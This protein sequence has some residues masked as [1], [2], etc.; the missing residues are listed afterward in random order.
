MIARIKFGARWLWAQGDYPRLAT[1]LEP[2]AVALARRCVRR[3]AEVLDVAAGNGNFALEAARLGARVTASDFTPHML[4]LGSER[5]R[6]EGLD[7]EWLEGDAESL[8]F[9]DASFD[10]VASVFGAMFAP[11]PDLVASEL[12][13]VVRPGGVVAMANYGIGGFLGRLSTVIAAFST[14]PAPTMPSPFLWGDEAEV[15]LRFERL[16]ASIEVEPRTLSLHFASMAEWEASFAASNPPIMA[17]KTILPPE[18][19]E[20]LLEQSRELVDAMNTARDGG[21]ITLESDYLVV[22][23]TSPRGSPPRRMA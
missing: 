20:R 16:A 8:P 12:F 19:Y 13:R 7:I 18:G 21:G 23:A 11:R 4:D 15:R 3:G 10:I 22:L 6:Q 9:P 14:T 1:M 17:M 2:E 5:S